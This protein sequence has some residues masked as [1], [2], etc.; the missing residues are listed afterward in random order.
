MD[1]PN[2]TTPNF[3]T[4]FNDFIYNCNKHGI[5]VYNELEITKPGALVIETVLEGTLIAAKLKTFTSYCTL[6]RR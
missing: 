5:V 3:K 2:R 1:F 4:H 6:K